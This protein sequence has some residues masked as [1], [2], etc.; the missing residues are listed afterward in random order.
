MGHNKCSNIWILFQCGNRHW[1][2]M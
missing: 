1:D 2:C